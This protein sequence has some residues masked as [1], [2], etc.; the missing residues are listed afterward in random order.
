[1]LPAC[2]LAAQLEATEVPLVL[3]DQTSLIATSIFGDF[4]VYSEGFLKYA[5]AHDSFHL[6]PVCIDRKIV[7][8]AISKLDFN[9]SADTVLLVGPSML[10][11]V[12]PPPRKQD[13]VLNLS[14]EWTTSIFLRENDVPIVDAM[15]PRQC[16]DHIC[17]L[18]TAGVLRFLHVIS[19]IVTKIITTIYD[20]RDFCF[21]VSQ[22]GR[23]GLFVVTCDQLSVVSPIAPRKCCAPR[24]ELDKMHVA[25]MDQLQYGKE[26][27]VSNQASKTKQWLN[28]TFLETSSDLRGALCSQTD[29]C[30]WSSANEERHLVDT[31]L[32]TCSIS[33]R[34]TQIC[35]PLQ[36]CLHDN[37]RFVVLA[38]ATEDCRIH[39]LATNN[40]VFTPVWQRTLLFEDVMHHV[41][42]LLLLHS[43][44]AVISRLDFIGSELYCFHSRG[45]AV[46]DIHWLKKS[47][48]S[49][50]HLSRVISASQTHCRHIIF[51]CDNLVGAAL[52][53][54]K[55][56]GLR[57]IICWFDSGSCCVVNS[58]A[59]QFVQHK[60]GVPGHP[61]LDTLCLIA[62]ASLI[63]N[64]MSGKLKC[65]P[66]QAVNIMIPPYSPQ[67]AVL[68][69]R[70]MCESLE[71]TVI[72]EHHRFAELY[73]AIAQ[74]IHTIHATQQHQFNRSSKRINVLADGLRAIKTIA[75][76][77]MTQQQSFRDR[78]AIL[79]AVVAEICPTLSHSEILYFNDLF[80]LAIQNMRVGDRIYT[81]MEQVQKTHQIVV[82][83]V[84]IALNQTHLKLVHELLTSQ[85]EHL[86]QASNKIC[87]SRHDAAGI[88][89]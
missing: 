42:S 72:A 45:A 48:R 86:F 22:W 50:H 85:I 32:S 58:T 20:A 61:I 30:K 26:K 89:G 2:L 31:P 57:E 44:H 7:E 10:G 38:I 47:L 67:G 83:D 69:L 15:F 54:K 62:E 84:P 24:P 29:S 4:L 49:G 16:D 37:G 8:E 60:A 5:H 52:M 70:N 9:K 27:A 75:N 46:L 23:F 63:L 81:E 1:M 18:N 80:S 40:N 33:L 36:I 14:Y 59:S 41:E 64:G 35:R 74:V 13:G 76:K 34:R 82:D 6:R 78:A 43:K 68:K 55:A 17:I 73:A 51:S 87:S 3:E 79:A 28:N 65:I 71:T 11:V 19:G 39:L 12:L 21:G 66:M 56:S 25:C 88:T 53:K 77:T